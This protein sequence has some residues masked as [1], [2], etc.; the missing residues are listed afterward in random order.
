MRRGAVP[1]PRRGPLLPARLAVHVLHVGRA[2]PRRDQ[3]GVLA[4]RGGGGRA[5]A[6]VPAPAAH[7]GRARPGAGRRAP[8]RPRL[9]AAT[10]GL[11]SAGAV[12]AAGGGTRDLLPVRTL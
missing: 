10:V 3:P 5:V 12:P 4:G 2:A 6:D 9:G 8:G 1:R 11:R 7:T